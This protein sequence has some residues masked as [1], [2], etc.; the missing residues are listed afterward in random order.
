MG[1]RLTTPFR[2]LH[3]VL[4]LTATLARGLELLAARKAVAETRTGRI[5]AA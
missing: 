5:V 2:V 4:G 1:K 3:V